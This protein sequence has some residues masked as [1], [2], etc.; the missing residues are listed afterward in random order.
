M[1]E[2]VKQVNLLK[3]TLETVVQRQEQIFKLQEERLNAFLERAESLKQ[4]Q[5]RQELINQS[6]Q[7]SLSE[8]DRTLDDLAK[9]TAALV[10]V[11][12]FLEKQ[13]KIAA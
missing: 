10:K 11:Q 5:E 4:T 12:V 1:E 8:N 3:E 6:L 7:Q 13:Q 2:L 9:V